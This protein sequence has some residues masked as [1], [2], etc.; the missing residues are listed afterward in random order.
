M[1]LNSHMFNNRTDFTSLRKILKLLKEGQKYFGLIMICRQA[2]SIP[3]INN[4]KWKNEDIDRAWEIID[5]MMMRKKSDGLVNEELYRETLE[6]L[7]TMD[8]SSSLL[9]DCL[10]SELKEEKSVNIEETNPISDESLL[11][12]QPM[13]LRVDPEGRTSP[14]LRKRKHQTSNDDNQ[15]CL[16]S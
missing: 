1:S 2:K 5:I 15:S 14:K 16:I 6:Y 10:K 12:F 3:N 8:K 7:E 11:D 9:I 13:V 4:S